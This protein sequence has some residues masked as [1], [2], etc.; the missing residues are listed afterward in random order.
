M[1]LKILT[2]V[3]TPGMAYSIHDQSLN[4]R[5]VKPQTISQARFKSDGSRSMAEKCS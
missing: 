1:L 3:T 4:S 5:A 2:A